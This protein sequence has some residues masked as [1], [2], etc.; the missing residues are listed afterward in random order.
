MRTRRRGVSSIKLLVGL[1]AILTVAWMG[2]E[3]GLV[4]RAVQQAKIAADAAAL[5]AAARLS[6]DFEIYSEAAVE[7]AAANRGPGG[8]IIIQIAPDN[9]GGDLLLG[10]WDS[11]TGTFT[12]DPDILDAVAV[13][14]R[15]GAAAPNPSPGFILP[16]LLELADAT[17]ERTS[18]ATWIP[19]P[20]AASLMIRDGN[21]VR[22]SLDLSGNSMLESEGDIEVRSNHF[23]A[24]WV[25]DDASVTVPTLRIA[26]GVHENDGQRVDGLI[27]TDASIM[28]DPYLDTPVPDRAPLAAVIDLF[29]PVSA[30]P[31]EP[32]RH[33]DGLLI[34]QGSVTLLPGI[35]Q[36]GGIGLHIGGDAEVILRNAS[37][38]L[39]DEGTLKISDSGSLSGT[40]IAYGDWNDV[41]LIAPDAESI[42]I[43]DQASAIVPGVC[44]C[45]LSFMRLEQNAA[46]VVDGLISGKLVQNQAS[47]ARMDRVIVAAPTEITARARLRR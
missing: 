46:L 33:P 38:Q 15:I 21:D 35:H 4:L 29:D 22:R 44:Y 31:L 30:T 18:V 45:P 9:T 6:S 3:F 28:E 2:I 32:G 42:T 47:T 40:T 8:E 27:E 12:P 36:F 26:G 14:V 7:A 24:V 43:R 34:D 13:T 1:P 23:A 20:P 25:S 39:L 19:L 5:A 41:F 17:F 16:N 37:I 11:T 10:S